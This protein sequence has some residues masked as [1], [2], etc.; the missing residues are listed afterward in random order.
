MTIKK[1]FENN[2]EIIGSVVTGLSVGLAVYFGLRGKR[3]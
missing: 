3:A 1:Y 2:P